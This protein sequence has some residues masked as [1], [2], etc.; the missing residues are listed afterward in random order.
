MKWS[1][2]ICLFGFLHSAISFSFLQLHIIYENEGK[3]EEIA[4]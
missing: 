3:E 4:E 2:S 1:Q